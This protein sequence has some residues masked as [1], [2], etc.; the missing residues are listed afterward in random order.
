MAQARTETL[1]QVQHGANLMAG[2]GTSVGG[3]ID[4]QVATARR[5]PRSLAQFKK[6]ALEMVTLDEDTAASCFYSIPRAGKFIEGKSVRLAEIAASAYQHIVIGV[7]ILEED[8]KFIYAEGV[9]WDLQRNYK[10]IK[11]SRRRITTK[12]GTRYNDDM[13]A[14][15]ANAAASIAFR[16][17]VFACIRRHLPRASTTRQ[18]RSPSAALRR[19]RRGGTR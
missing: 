17:A 3:E 2:T 18:K 7:R 13:I 1:P 11:P 16:N 8:D 4:I 5:F 15:T 6:D 9:A 19:W 12:N 14:V 10:V